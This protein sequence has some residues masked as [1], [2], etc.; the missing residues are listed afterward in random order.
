M[1]K[2]FFSTTKT[3]SN[4]Y[5]PNR[6]RSLNLV[7]T[8]TSTSR[9]PFLTIDAT[10]YFFGVWP[11]LFCYFFAALGKKAEEKRA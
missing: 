7:F 2:G 1:N 5:S 8:V 11:A 9:F 4:T 3:A 6:Y 10:F